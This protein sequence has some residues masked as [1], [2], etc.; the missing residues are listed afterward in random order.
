MM[1]RLPSSERSHFSGR[2]S[3]MTRTY[4]FNNEDAHVPSSDRRGPLGGQTFWTR[5]QVFQLAATGLVTGL[6]AAPFVEQGL[7]ALAS[8]ASPVATPLPWPAANDILATTTVPSFPSTTFP[9]TTYGAKGDGHT[10]NT[11]AFA[12]A[13]A[14]CNAAGG[15]HVVVPSGTYSTGAIHLLSNVDFH[16]NSG[17]TLMFNGNAANYPPVLTRYEGIECLNHSPMVYAYKQTNIA[18]TGSGMLDASGTASWNKGSDRAG[19]LEPLVNLPPTQRNVV[20]KL[21]S[22]F[23]EPYSCSN[24]LIQGVTLRNAIFWQLHP[25]LC[26][27][28]TV[29]GV[30]TNHSG[31]NTDGCDPECCDHV[32]I[33]NSTIRA[34]DD[35]IAIKSGRDADGRRIH[36]PTQNVVI[37]NNQFEGPWGAITLGSELTG[38]IENVY[39]FSNSVIGTGT[40][41]A[42]YVKSNTQRGGFA[43]NINIDT[44]RAT[45]FSHAVVFITMHYN[46]QTGSFPPDFGGPFNLNN[47]TVAGA[48]QVLDL[49]GIASDRIGNVNV[50]NSTFSGIANATNTISNV[51]KVTLTNVTINVKP[52]H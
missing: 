17:A 48:A 24:I 12:K 45:H 10:D 5:R 15:G 6:A 16:L 37:W 1:G 4:P 47:F 25:T 49:D 21:R 42:H 44:L 34:G 50:S 27:N 11:A 51:T 35:N 8:P 38:G 40:R 43:R 30:T 3:H 28:V 26:T 13:I 31:S 52:V 36:V 33:K 7:Q 2:K 39:A 18:L 20:G 23:V 32:V 22:T 29:D 41:F 14:A 19:V 9:V 46:S